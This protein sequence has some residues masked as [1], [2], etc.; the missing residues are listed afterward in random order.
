M[1]LA[2]TSRR[3]WIAAEVSTLEKERRA[4]R[5]RASARGKNAM[6][7]GVGARIFTRAEGRYAKLL[8]LPSLFAKLL[9]S[10][11]SYFP[12]NRCMPS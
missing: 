10:F 12:K 11:F 7:S 1:T 4:G 9:V 2:S 3:R 5:R 8:F 6:A